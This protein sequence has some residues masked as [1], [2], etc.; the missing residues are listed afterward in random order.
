M[1]TKI[2]KCRICGNEELTEVIDLGVQALTGVFPKTRDQKI[3]SGPLRLVKCGGAPTAC[4][5]VQLEHTFELSEMYGMNYGYRSGLNSSMVRHLR[6]KVQSILKWITPPDGALVMDIGSNDSTTLQ[7]YPDRLTLVGVDPTGVK[8]K[9]YYPSHIELI[10]DFFSAEKV[11]QRFGR[12][13][14]SIITSFSMF[15]D[16]PDPGAFVRDIAEVLA[17]DGV[18]IFEQS[19]L[20]SMLEHNSFDTVCHEHLEYY[21]LK[22]ISWMAERAGLQLI[23][24]ELNDVNGGSFSVI[25]AKRNSALRPSKRIAEIQSR[26]R[27]LQLDSMA[28]YLEFS[29]SVR[30]RREELRAFLDK[31]RDSGLRVCGLGA[32]TK[33]NVL[34]Q[35]CEIDERLIQ[36]IGD[37]NPEKHGSFTPGSLIPIADED[38]VVGDSPDYLVVLPWHFRSFFEDNEKFT[39]KR[40]VFPLPVLEI[41]GARGADDRTGRR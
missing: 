36:R 25:A 16:L 8:F 22:Q 6:S 20:P 7:A 41:S 19:Y 10:P 5:L 38:E 37:V 9:E 2:D 18:W 11:R 17:D 33:G 1:Y 34:L 3:V 39:G 35:Y 12:K 21:T 14:A 23:D 15:Y 30:R 27:E 13:K 24:V 40:L 4:G 31:A 29:C 32:S 28:P 26:E